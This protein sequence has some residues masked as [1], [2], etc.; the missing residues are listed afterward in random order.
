MSAL[1]LSACTTGS[2]DIVTEDRTV[3]DFDRIE[4]SSAVTVELVVEPGAETTV[5][6]AY[7]DNLI[8]RVKTEVRS[9]TLF[10]SVDGNIAASGD[11]RFVSVTV[12]SLEAIEVSGAV[13]LKG[14]GEVNTYDLAVSGASDVD[15][16]DLIA[17]EVTI[18]VGGASEV[19]IWASQSVTGDVSGASDVTVHGDPGTVN[20]ET[21]G[22]SDLRM[23]N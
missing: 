19:S 4:I 6:V 23:A 2:G 3:D 21:S 12:D 5:S 11:R 8:D 17:N 10:I 20:V 14:S 22:V 7:D 15:L 16:R 13:D 1:V 9:A 18:Q